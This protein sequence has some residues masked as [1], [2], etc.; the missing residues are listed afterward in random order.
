MNLKRPWRGLNDPA[1]ERVAV[2]QTY[3]FIA[4]D[5]LVGSSAHLRDRGHN[6][7]GLNGR[8]VG[9]VALHCANQHRSRL[10]VDGHN[11]DHR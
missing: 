4:V 6:F 8:A 9:A 2:S 3:L 10:T 5:G 1:M 7:A 11:T